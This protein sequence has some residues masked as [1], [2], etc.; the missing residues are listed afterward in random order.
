MDRF[1]WSRSKAVFASTVF[2]FVVGIPSA[3]NLDILGKMDGVFGGVLLILGGFVL[4]IFLG[5]IVPGRF[6][7]DLAGCESNQRVRRYLKFMLR[8]V[9]PPAIAFGLIVSLID[10]FNSWSA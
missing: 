8:W 2:L 10:L 1:G 9:S 3:M 4:S 6:D 7:E 5:W